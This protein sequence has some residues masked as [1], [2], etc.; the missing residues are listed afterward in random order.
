MEEEIDKRL[1]R[2]TDFQHP[3]IDAS[4]QLRLLQAVQ[5]ETGHGVCCVFTVISFAEI[6]FIPYKALSYTWGKAHGE[7]DVQKI[8]VAEQPFF[9]R[10][11]LFQFLH[12]AVYKGE[13]GLFFIDAICINQLDCNE[14]Q[15]QV[16][17]MARIFRNAREVIAW[18]GTPDSDQLSNVQALNSAKNKDCVTWRKQ[19]WE[20]FKYL[21][22]TQYWSRIWVVQ[23]ILL[24]SN[25]VVWCGLFAFPL[26]LFGRGCKIDDWK[27]TRFAA[28]GR[29]STIG[30]D[31]ARV[32]TPAESI[33]THRLRYFIRPA[34]HAL[35]EGFIVGTLEEMTTRLTKPSTV[36]Q[37]YQSQIPDSIRETVRKFGKLECSDHRDKLYGLLGILNEHS[38]AKVQP[39]YTRDISYAFYQALKVGIE[40]MWPPDESAVVPQWVEDIEG[41]YVGYYCDARDAFGLGDD[42]SIPILRRVLRELGFRARMQDAAFEAQLQQQ[43]GWCDLEVSHYKNFRKMVIDLDA[44]E[45]EAA[46][47]LMF[48]FHTKQRGMAERMLDSLKIV[49]NS[50]GGWRRLKEYR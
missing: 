6:P 8:Q 43:F 47:G 42:M 1:N 14:R 34:S 15:G 20:A 44:E 50:G 45:T 37:T 24:A 46:P 4:S 28:D 33:I 40:E 2:Q 36:V 3:S 17:E 21:S 18:L 27:R 26:A 32:Q 41:A 22:Y 29:P 30:S 39:D 49:R 11:N 23:E 13:I 35:T 16:R 12:T 10:R 48:R 9:V 7:R 19:Q 25:L 31:S 5:D 38:Q